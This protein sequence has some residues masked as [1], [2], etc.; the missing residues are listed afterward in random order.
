MSFDVYSMLML[1]PVPN[2]EY[3]KEK[4][5]YDDDHNDDEEKDTTFTLKT[6]TFSRVVRFSRRIATP[7]SYLCHEMCLNR[8]CRMVATQ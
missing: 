6:K 8:A 4:K 5:R 7:N 3:E 1:G 2:S